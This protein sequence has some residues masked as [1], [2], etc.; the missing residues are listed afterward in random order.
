MFASVPEVLTFVSVP[1]ATEYECQ[2]PDTDGFMVLLA[3]RSIVQQRRAI[4]CPVR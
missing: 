3:M 1:A 2:N 4:F